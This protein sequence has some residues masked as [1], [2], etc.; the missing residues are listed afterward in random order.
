MVEQKAALKT[1]E[2]GVPAQKTNTAGRHV[3]G[4]IVLREVDLVVRGDHRDLR[5]ASDA[6]V[7]QPLA[8][9]SAR[10]GA[11]AG[12]RRQPDEFA[13]DPRRAGGASHLSGPPRNRWRGRR[14]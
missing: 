4:E 7:I 8:R 1:A 12:R 10:T 13:D 11:P 5:L 6:A 3:I 14:C 9:V 2:S